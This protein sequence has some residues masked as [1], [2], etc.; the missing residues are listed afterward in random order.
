MSRGCD[1]EGM[2]LVNVLM[3]VAIAAGL[4]LLMINREELALDRGLR[5]REAARALAIV[6]GGEL[7]ALVALR[8]DAEQSPEVDHVGEPWAKLS[9][10]GAPIEGGTFDLAI[11]DA[12]GR[13]NINSVR[14]GEVAS[15]VLFQ[16]IGN[17]AG[18]TG[19]QIVAAIE[20][21]RLRGPV[22]DLRPL[23]MA[24]VEPKVAD[25]LERLVTALPGR[26]TLNL[27][28]ADEGMLA[29]LFRD[30]VVA[31]R[32]V[33]IRARQGYLT[34]KDLADQNVSLPWGTTFRSNTFWVRTRAT[35]GGTSQ[36]AATLI[37]RRRAPD[38]AVD[39]FPVERWRNAAVPPGAPVLPAAKS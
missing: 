8:R 24:G 27:N 7:S 18:M 2:I 36:Q 26:T 31:Q 10:N 15:T 21:V 25:R 30:P 22:T 34:A 29:L 17:D 12:E 37:Q 9:E 33:A 23:R 3:F 38:G 19:E 39:V 1:E 14:T 4:V 32:L 6:R 35:I 16:A 11:A 28:A 13:F 5:T 20:Y